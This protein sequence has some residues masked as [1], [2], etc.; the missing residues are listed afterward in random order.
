M[1]LYF[2]HVMGTHSVAHQGG[3]VRVRCRARIG[4]HERVRTEDMAG[5]SLEDTLLRVR[6]C[7]SRQQARRQ[8]LQLT[9]RVITH[10]LAEL[11]PVV[12]LVLC[13]W[14]YLHL[15]VFAHLKLVGQGRPLATQGLEGLVLLAKACLVE[16]REEHALARSLLGSLPA[17]RYGIAARS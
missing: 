4:H 2:H 15:E 12:R 9:H 5:I 16:G 8:H 13:R 1:P 7:L 3:I 14:S 17:E 10:W 11:A 6:L